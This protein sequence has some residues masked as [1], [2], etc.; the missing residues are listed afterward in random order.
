MSAMQIFALNAARA[1]RSHLEQLAGILVQDA[2][3]PAAMRQ[4][5][6]ASLT[7]VNDVI[8]SIEKALE[9]P[10]PVK[11]VVDVMVTATADPI[12]TA[13]EIHRAIDRYRD[14]VDALPTLPRRIP[15]ATLS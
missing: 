6:A 2:T 15:G 9:A 8:D 4:Q 13:R 1:G 5:V 3:A 11:P 12:S 10:K 7:E 14:G